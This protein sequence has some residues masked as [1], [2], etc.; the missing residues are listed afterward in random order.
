MWMAGG[1]SA[2]DAWQ[3]SHPEYL[4]PSRLLDAAAMVVFFVVPAA[5]FVIGPESMRPGFLAPFTKRYWQTYPQVCLRIVCWFLGGWLIWLVVY[6][7]Q[8]LL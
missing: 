3:H 6:G 7:R 8:Y 4:V 2:L 1:M 5:F